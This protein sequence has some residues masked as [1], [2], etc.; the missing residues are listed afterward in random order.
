MS[1]KKFDEVFGEEEQNKQ[2]NKLIKKRMNQKI[3]SKIFKMFIIISLII[4][5]CF[6]GISFLMDWMY[7]SPY[8]EEE[9]LEPSKHEEFFMLMSNY[10]NLDFPGIL[11]MQVDWEDENLYESQGMGCYETK[12][13]I[14]SIFEPLMIDGTSNTTIS[15]RRSQVLIDS[16]SYFPLTRIVNEFKDV[17]A[18]DFQEIYALSDIQ[19]EIE[20]L[21][22]SSYLDVS[23]SFH[24][25]VSL[26]MIASLIKKYPDVYFKWIA[27][28]DQQTSSVYGVAGGFSLYDPARYVFTSEYEKR[29]PYFYLEEEKTG[30]ILEQ[31]Y[32]SML[33][34]MCDHK[35]FVDA[36]SSYSGISYQ[37]YVDNYQKAQKE[38][39][40]YGVRVSVKK[41][42]LLDMIEKENISY[43][44]IHDIKLSQYQK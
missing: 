14:Q 26:D 33:K 3:Y 30:D 9:M 23:L 42:D 34:M 25:Y 37:K 21:P 24:E 38:L 40:A 28:K 13:K 22:D 27:L 8:R 32:L 35:D 11:L 16:G 39:L 7:Y 12:V 20:E 31:K 6:Y 43:A 2:F 36:L 17:N 41:N 1:D 10:V 19:K 15:I 29:Y 44:Y 18:K 4:T 5:S